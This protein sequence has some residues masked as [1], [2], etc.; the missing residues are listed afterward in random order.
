MP[1]F[2]VIFSCFHMKLRFNKIH[3]Q[4]RN[5]NVNIFLFLRF[6]L[7]NLWTTIYNSFL[8]SENSRNEIIF[9]YF[10]IKTVKSMTQN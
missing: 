7:M 1:Y 3:N 4:V 8:R 10:V 2:A 6:M 9:W 5:E